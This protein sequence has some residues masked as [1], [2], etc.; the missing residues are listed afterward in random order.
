MMQHVEFMETEF[1]RNI[2]W[3]KKLLN[4]LIG[5]DSHKNSSKRSSVVREQSEKCS[6]VRLNVN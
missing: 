2:E 3:Q 4:Q 6:T 5:E 1:M